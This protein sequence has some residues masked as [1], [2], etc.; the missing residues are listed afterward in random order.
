MKNLIKNIQTVVL[1][2]TLSLAMVASDAFGSSPIIDDDFKSS[3]YRGVKHRS[4]SQKD[5]K[6]FRDK[7]TRK[8]YSKRTNKSERTCVS[9]IPRLERFF[10][11]NVK[12]K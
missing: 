12:K 6:K 2:S 3:N 8:D 1:V 7:K 4:I 10:Y 9:T 5:Y 11:E